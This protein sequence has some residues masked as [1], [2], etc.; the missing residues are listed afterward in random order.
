[1]SGKLSGVRV[2]DLTRVLAGPLVGQMLADLGAEVIKVE[3]PGSGD[4][5]RRYGP[6]FCGDQAD[7]GSAFFLAANR[8]KRS[9]TID[10]AQPEGQRL[11][12]DLVRG[13]DVL[14]E[15]FRVGTLARYGL[16]SATLRAANP[17]LIYCSITGF[18]QTGPNRERP[19]YDAIF[20]AMGGLMSCIGHPDGEPGG[21]PM[22]TGLSITDV[23]TSLYADIAVVSALYAR[24]AN[25]GR[26]DH[27]DI[28]LLDA[29]VA[30][31]SHYAMHY[32]IS[33][34]VPPRR[35]NAGNGGVPSQLFHCREGA[36][37]LTV[38]NDAQFVRFCAALG[39]P[40]LALDPRFASGVERIRHRDTLIPLLERIFLTQDAAHWLQ[41]LVNADIPV[42]AIN[43]MAAVFDD[44]QVQQRQLRRPAEGSAFGRLDLVANPIRYAEQ[45]LHRYQAP[46]RLG[47][48]TDAVLSQQLG[49]GAA[50]LAALRDKAVI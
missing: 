27:I 44:P 1:M 49:L 3:Q 2:I 39:Q 28:A 12:S 34:Q 7:G 10:F 24:Q 22:R 33:G 36:L 9:I 32:L 5:S 45:P 16:D 31:M 26:G 48:H 11:V 4:E 38:G 50:E 15:N 21:G 42:G 37:M 41:V 8:N 25:G 17:G 13:A 35:G 30:T 6:P 46:P 23:I 40:G 47:E 43:D 19:G 29:T 20:Q 14:L 18:G